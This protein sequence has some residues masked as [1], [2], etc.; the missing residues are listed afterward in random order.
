[1]AVDLDE[2]FRRATEKFYAGNS[3]E[4]YEKAAGEKVKYNK[5]YFDEFEKG[6]RPKPKKGKK[7]E[8]L[9]ALESEELGDEGEVDVDD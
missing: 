5:E 7:E 8:D 9:E 3:F 4:N 2:A 1:M 6:L